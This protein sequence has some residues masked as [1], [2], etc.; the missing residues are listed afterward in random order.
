MTDAMDAG[1]PTGTTP[2]T[3]AAV[4]RERLSRRAGMQRLDVSRTT[5]ARGSELQL[6]PSGAGRETFLYIL[7]GRGVLTANGESVALAAGDCFGF[8]G[9]ALPPR[10][11]NPYADELVCL[12]TTQ[13]QPGD[14]AGGNT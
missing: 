8:A 6:S 12:I 10:L 9:P 4:R 2:P 11:S 1:A 13:I 5:L 3:V 7:L 14:D